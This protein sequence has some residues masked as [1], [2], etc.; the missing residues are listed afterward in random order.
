MNLIKFTHLTKN[1]KV[2]GFWACKRA[3]SKYSQSYPE[4]FLDRVY[5]LFD[6]AKNSKV[7]HLFSGSLDDQYTVDLNPES[8]SKF[9]EDAIRTHF[10]DNFFD[11]VL[12]YPPYNE[13]RAKDWGFKLPTIKSILE[14][15]RR[16]VKPGGYYCLLHFIVPRDWFKER[17]GTIAV[18]EG[19]NMRIR[20]FSIFKKGGTISIDDF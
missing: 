15:E 14:E 18:T 11:L 5:E 12:A 4:D 16:I 8:P 6:I 9:K 2:Y 10:E 13:E 1:G 20:A 3:Y 17:A 7:C 19:A